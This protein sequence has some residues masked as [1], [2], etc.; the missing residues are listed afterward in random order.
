MLNWQWL[1]PLGPMTDRLYG[2]LTDQ[3]LVT[4]TNDWHRLTSGT[5]HL[6]G[7]IFEQRLTTRIT[8]QLLAI[9]AN[10]WSLEP[11]SDQ[12]LSTGTIDWYCLTSRTCHWDEWLNT[13][14]SLG[15][16]TDHWLTSIGPITDHKR[17]EWQVQQLT[18]HCDLLLATGTNHWPV[19]QH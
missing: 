4:W 13:N 6:L 10:D 16:L 12:W 15:S 5:S 14:W 19:T 8:D 3:S 18:D 1:R 9:E 17:Y 2:W 11:A 7:Q